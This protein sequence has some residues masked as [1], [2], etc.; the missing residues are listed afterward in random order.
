M[1][2]KS[3]GTNVHIKVICMFLGTDWE[4]DD[5]DGGAGNIGSVI[6]VQSTGIVF[7]R[8]LTN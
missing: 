2:N 5:Q 6:S 8:L 4:W 1:Q 3:G 7:V